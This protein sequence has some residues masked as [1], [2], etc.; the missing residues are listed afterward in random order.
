MA[1]VD[2]PATVTSA[3]AG[4]VAVFVGVWGV[5]S[6]PHDDRIS[7]VRASTKTVRV[8]ASPRAVAVDATTIVNIVADLVAPF[9]GSSPKGLIGSRART[10]APYTACRDISLNINTPLFKHQRSQSDQ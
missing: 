9:L 3:V 10:V 6:P 1:V 2:A 8:M 5:V 4:V 7:K